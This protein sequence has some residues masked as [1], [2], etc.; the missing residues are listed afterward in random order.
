M[1]ID[2]YVDTHAPLMDHVQARGCERYLQILRALARTRKY[3]ISI[4]L[5]R[6]K[7]IKKMKIKID[8]ND[9]ITIW[10]E[11]YLGTRLLG[12]QIKI[13]TFCGVRLCFVRKIDLSGL[14]VD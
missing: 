3:L 10:L 9:S 12:H 7:K 14:L 1:Y 11:C 4:K 8:S 6:V 13:F 2:G 5:C